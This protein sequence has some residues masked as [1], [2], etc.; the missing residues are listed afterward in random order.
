MVQCF[1]LENNYPS[2]PLIKKNKGFNVLFI[3]KIMYIL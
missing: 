2:F 1:I 3:N